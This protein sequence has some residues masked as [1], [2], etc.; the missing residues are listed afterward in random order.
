MEILKKLSVIFKISVDELIDNAE[1]YKETLSAEE[2]KFIYD[3]H[4]LPNDFKKQIIG[5]LHCI[6]DNKKF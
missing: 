6:I 1:N 2:K 5:Y 3:F 4:N